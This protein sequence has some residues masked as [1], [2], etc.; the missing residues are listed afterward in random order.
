MTN[1]PKARDHGT[2]LIDPYGI[3]GTRTANRLRNMR[4][5]QRLQQ[6]VL[7][8]IILGLVGLGVYS[9]RTHRI[10]TLKS[11]ANWSL[12]VSPSA[13]PAWDPQYQN[14][15]IPTRDGQIVAT[16]PL[17]RPVHS[18]ILLE[19]DFPLHGTPVL[20]EK[21]FYTGSENGSLYALDRQTG[22]LIW[23]YNSGAA[24][25][26][27]PQVLGNLVF[28]GNDAGWL[29][30]LRTDKGQI[31]WKRKLPSSIGDGLATVSI[32]TKLVLAPL[33]DGA[34][35]R[36][37][38]WALD[39]NT[40]IVKWKFPENGITNAQQ[41]SPP[42]TIDIDGRTRVICANDTGA[43]INLNAANG[44]YAGSDDGWKVY[45]QN[46]T[47]PASRVMFRSPPLFEPQSSPTRLYINGNDDVV[48][49]VD[50]YNGHL[51]WKWRAPAIITG[52]MQLAGGQIVVPCRGAVSYLLNMN[53]GD[54]DAT[55][56]GTKFP[57]VSLLRVDQNIWAVDNRGTLSR[58][59]LS[60]K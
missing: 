30:C 40:G 18:R 58:Y 31:G 42:V 41:I 24:I 56:T 47:H 17:S 53:T 60:K 49:C 33:T 39:A 57:I 25:S 14:L 46:E 32:P 15:L 48:R 3:Y 6:Y 22:Q 50:I 43:L 5:R 36:G 10:P 7:T 1:P 28:C 54:V 13:T 52:S 37:G 23:Q 20:D 38:V 2:A 12:L 19:T 4:R 55:L 29:F 45:F 51:L 27:Q 34:A 11:S 44:K 9:W 59:S 35:Q 16:W 21:Y 26:T 8:L